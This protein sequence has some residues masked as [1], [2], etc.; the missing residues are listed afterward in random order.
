MFHL[1][2]IVL[3][4]LLYNMKKFNILFI[5]ASG[6]FLMAFC[7]ESN[8][9]PMNENKISLHE[10]IVEDINGDSYDFSKLKGKKVMVVN[11]AS[12]CGL[13]PQYEALEALYKAYGSSDFTIV[14]FPSNNF[15]GQEPGSDAEILTFCKKNYGVTF[16]LMSKVDVKGKGKCS[17]YKFLTEKS[18]NGLKDSEVKWNFQKYLIDE[19]GFLELVIPPRT[20]PNDPEIIAWIKN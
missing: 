4:V 19:N 6:I 9:K 17:V 20:A 2:F 18:L 5:L 16:P 1:N 11:T 8:S 10:Y 7:M 3:K 14:A 12:K 13:T 15:M